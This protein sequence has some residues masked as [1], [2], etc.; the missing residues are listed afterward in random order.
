MMWGG[1]GTCGSIICGG[2]GNVAPSCGVEG[3]HIVIIIF[4]FV[5]CRYRC[6]RCFNFD[7]CQSCFF[8]GRKAKGHKLTHPMQEYCTAV[9]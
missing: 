8:S 7:M 2:N 1:D 9:R 3:R 5:F 4:V 6:L